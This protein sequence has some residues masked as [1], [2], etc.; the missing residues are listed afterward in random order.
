MD[1]PDHKFETA[2]VICAWCGVGGAKAI[3]VLE[4]PITYFSGFTL[5]DW[6]A[7]AALIYSLMQITLMF[8][9]WVRTVKGWFHGIFQ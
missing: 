3:E 8:P 4:H 7:L 5:S 1:T 9:R 2:K 6:A